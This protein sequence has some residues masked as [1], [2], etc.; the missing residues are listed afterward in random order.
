MIARLLI[1]GSSG[2]LASQLKPYRKSHPDVLFFG[3][4]EKLGIA[5]ARKIKDHFSLKPHSAKGKTVVIED[6]SL[7]TEEA[8]NALL[9]T[10]E[11]LP[12]DAEFILAASS[13]STFL[14]TILSRCRIEYLSGNPSSENTGHNIAELQSFS[15]EER[16]EYVERIK[17]REELLFSLL[18]Y[19]RSN[20]AEY[21]QFTAKVLEAC[22][23]H[24]QNVNIRAI[25]E[26]LMLEMPH[27]K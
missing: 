2:A 10:L 1:S 16:F 12:E 13:E 11:E 4:E 19:F 3:A 23:W 25:L 22:K 7:M 5:E 26:Y 15:K 8:Q 9:K 21:P 27:L 18:S 6:A 17:N 24:K 14:P 20:I